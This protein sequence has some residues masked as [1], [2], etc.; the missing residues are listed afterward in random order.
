MLHIVMAQKIP[1][2]WEVSSFTYTPFNQT[3]NVLTHSP[4]ASGNPRK[5]VYSQGTRQVSWGGAWRIKTQV[6]IFKTEDWGHR[7]LGRPSLNAN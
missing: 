5:Y 2:H 7:S 4:F 6:A 3:S 1:Q